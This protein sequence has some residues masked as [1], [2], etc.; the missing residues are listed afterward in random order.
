MDVGSMLYFFNKDETTGISALKTSQELTSQSDR[1]NVLPEYKSAPSNSRKHMGR[2]S[3][4]IGKGHELLPKTNGVFTLAHSVK[5]LEGV[6]G[7]A[8]I[9][10]RRATDRRLTLFGKYIS[11]PRI[12]TLEG[13]AGISKSDIVRVRVCVSERWSARVRGFEGGKKNGVEGM[14]CRKVNNK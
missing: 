6:F 9:V 10:I 13:L 4:V 8:L 14:R 5:V 12:P 11:M 7:D 3:L 2:Y 1:V